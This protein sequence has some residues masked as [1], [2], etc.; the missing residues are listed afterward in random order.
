MGVLVPLF[1]I[2]SRSSWGIGEI[3]DLVRLARWV[4]R[5]GMDFVQILPVNE[6]QDGQN[7]PYSALSAM[8]ID[9]IF[10]SLSDVEEHVAVEAESLMSLDD[11]NRLEEARC[12]PAVLHP[13]VRALKQNALRDAFSRFE[14]G[15]LKSHD[16]RAL[17]FRD[18]TERE[19]WWLDDYALFRALHEEHH[20]K[21]WLEWPPALRDREPSALSEAEVRLA[22]GDP[23]LQVRAVGRGRTMAGCACGVGARRDLWRFSLHGQR[24]Q[25]RRLGAPGGVPGRCVG[26]CAA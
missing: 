15:D 19:A 6:M 1:S 13:L 3:P 22:K 26:R 4:D 11:L 5:A 24:S 18:F 9:P 12:A 8:A 10:I 7:S 16:S 23:L 25:R 21:Y 2:P 14:R 20:G 17:Q